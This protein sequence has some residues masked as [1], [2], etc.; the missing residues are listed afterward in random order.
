M[1]QIL[2]YFTYFVVK[3]ISNKLQNLDMMVSDT[4]NGVGAP[5]LV[6]HGGVGADPAPAML[7]FT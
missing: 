1:N 7:T 4:V 6:N 2:F 3:R 5:A